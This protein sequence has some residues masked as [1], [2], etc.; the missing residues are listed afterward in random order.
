[1][2]NDI[3]EQK[4]NS[5]IEAGR[6][7]VSTIL[8]EMQ[9]EMENRK[10]LIVKPAA[11]QFI[12]QEKDFKVSIND[13]ILNFT[14]YSRGQI[15]GRAGIPVAYADKLLQLGENELLLNNLNTMIER[16][17]EDGLL[18]RKI[19]EDIR[20]VLSPSYRRMDASPVFEGFIDG[21]I[22]TGYVPYNGNIT[23]YR[24]NITFIYPEIFNPTPN[25]FIVLG[26]S[27]TTGDY[28]TSAL[29]LELTTLRI[30]CLNLA[31]GTDIFRKIHIGKR[32][33][34]AEDLIELS[35]KTHEL[36]S[37]AVASAISDAVK[38]SL[39][40][41]ENVKERIKRSAQ[42]GLSIKDE[43]AK[44]KKKGFR[45]ELAESVKTTF[46]SELP[47]ELLPQEKTVWRFSNA[48]SLLANQKSGDDRLDL[49]NYAMS[50]LSE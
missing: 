19:N 15:L 32:F 7:K 23:D 1:M 49:Q 34:S 24:Y 27:I 44:M 21:A 12:T 50:V 13:E 48:I 16:Q 31:I 29:L 20:G 18:V 30:T 14:N 47:V 6:N 9:T 26:I 46:E 11:M 25:E 40:L 45:K 37:Q 8:Q 38:G 42:D 22:K 28:G 10:D 35:Q 17:C 33:E 41:Q 4:L 2:V 5:I 43:I 39:A 36:D 3:R